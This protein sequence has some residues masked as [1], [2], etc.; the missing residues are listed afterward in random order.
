M[1][2]GEPAG[3]TWLQ[4]GSNQTFGTHRHVI[5]DAIVRLVGDLGKREFLQ[6][7]SGARIRHVLLRR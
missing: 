4:S 1:L 5:R 2:W 7:S 3:Q 6:R